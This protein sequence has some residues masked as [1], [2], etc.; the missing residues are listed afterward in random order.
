VYL[1]IRKRADLRYIYRLLAVYVCQQA[2]I[3]IFYYINKQCQQKNGQKATFFAHL[4]P[5]VMSN[6]SNKNKKGWQYL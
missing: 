4:L 2:N 1:L 6:V 5:S 3:R